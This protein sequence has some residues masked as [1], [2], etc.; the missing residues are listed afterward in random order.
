MAASTYFGTRR[1][2]LRSDTFLNACPP[3]VKSVDFQGP[4]LESGLGDIEG[5]TAHGEVVHGAVGGGVVQSSY[6]AHKRLLID[7]TARQVCKNT[8]GERNSS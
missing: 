6:A 2:G 5:I 7:Q 3:P 1:Q 4:S 8:P